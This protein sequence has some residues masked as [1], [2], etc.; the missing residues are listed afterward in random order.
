M[1]LKYNTIYLL[2]NRKIKIIKHINDWIWYSYLD[3]PKY[4]YFLNNKKISNIK[5]LT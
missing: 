4:G 3:D 5:S 1:K 2:N